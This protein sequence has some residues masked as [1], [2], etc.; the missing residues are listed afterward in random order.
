VI[1]P[2]GGHGVFLNETNRYRGCFL[3]QEGDNAVD[4]RL[5]KLEGDSSVVL[6]LFGTGPDIA[7]EIGQRNIAAG[8]TSFD[9]EMSVLLSETN[10]GLE[11]STRVYVY[12]RH[13]DTNAEVVLRIEATSFTL[14][15]PGLAAQAVTKLMTEQA[16]AAP[17]PLPEGFRE[18]QMP[19]ALPLCADIDFAKPWLYDGT[20]ERMGFDS[21]TLNLTD[22]TAVRPASGAS[23]TRTAVNFTQAAA[24]FEPEADFWK[25]FMLQVPNDAA[26]ALFFVAPVE[27]LNSDIFYDDDFDDDGVAQSRSKLLDE[28][29]RFEFSC[30]FK[31]TRGWPSAE[32]PG[33]WTGSVY[34]TSPVVQSVLIDG[35]D[36]KPGSYACAGRTD[37]SGYA[38]GAMG[39]QI[40]ELRPGQSIRQ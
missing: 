34:D 19:L 35:S 1:F 8:T 26:G 4:T 36:F 15:T 6:Q 20:L 38:F 22:R 11:E 25:Y 33:L 21:S 29:A 40:F 30:N 18:T 7:T 37:V 14:L 17:V 27:A 28:S 16:G 2:G 31:D 39:I 23:G 13:L 24:Q 3:L 32:E 9:A 5:F 12:T 10:D